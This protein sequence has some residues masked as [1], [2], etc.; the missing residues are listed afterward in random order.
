MI[1]LFNF[2]ARKHKHGPCLKRIIR[3]THPLKPFPNSTKSKKNLSLQFTLQGTDISPLKGT[4]E[5]EFPFSQLG[6]I[7]SLEG[8]SL[9]RHS[10]H[11]LKP[12]DLDP[13]LP[14]SKT[15]SSNFPESFR[16]K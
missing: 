10:R 14:Q 5:D 8:N 6:Y 15:P 11:I 9:V 3:P 13:M 12:K 2:Y 4:F 1:F 16:Q 7:S